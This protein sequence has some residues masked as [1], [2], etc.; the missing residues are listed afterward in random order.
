MQEILIVGFLVESVIES[1]ALFTKG[2][3]PRVAFVLGVLG[4]WLFGVSLTALIGLAVVNYVEVVD[5][6]LL[7]FA[8]M[9]GSGFLNS[10]LE[11]FAR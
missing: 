9:R 2:W 10:L 3:K 4:S 6:A 7:G 5:A 8:V 11:K 1:I